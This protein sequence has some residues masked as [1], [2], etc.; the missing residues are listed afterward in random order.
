[1]NKADLEARAEEARNL[2]ASDLFAE[3]MTIVRT[4]AL[5][6]LSIVKAD[7]ILEIQRLQAI[8][9]CTDG[10][11]D[12]LVGAVLKAGERDGGVTA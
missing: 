1:M 11:K 10:L 4:D 8:V 7:D 3:A 2:L 9:H 5:M 12:A 6:G